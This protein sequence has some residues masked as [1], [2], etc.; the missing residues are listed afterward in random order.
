MVQRTCTGQT[1]SGDPCSAQ[2]VRYDGY[3]F[4]HSPSTVQERAESRRRGGQNRSNRARA[5]KALPDGLLSIDELRGVM[6]KALTD[7]IAGNLE[8][9]PANAAAALARVYLLTTEAA[10]VERIEERL[11]ELERIAA[12]GRLA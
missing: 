9:G 10:A 11:G 3:C 12:R 4:W 6:G 8:P 1:A 7:V 5:R 2:P